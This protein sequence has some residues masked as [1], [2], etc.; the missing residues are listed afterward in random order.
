MKKRLRSLVCLLVLFHSS[1][2]A[3]SGVIPQS[4]HPTHH[5]KIRVMDNRGTVLA[6][7]QVWKDGQP[8]ERTDV[9]GELLLP[10]RER[11][12]VLTFSR[13][14]YLPVTRAFQ[15][16][17]RNPVAVVILETLLLA[18]TISVTATVTP[19]SLQDLPRAQD[20]LDRLDIRSTLPFSPVEIAQTTPAVSF[21]G[22]G[23]Q[24]ITPTI[25]GTGRRRILLLLNGVRV[26]SDRRAGTSA[27]FIPAPWITTMEVVR[28]PGSV[29]FGSDAIGGV[30]TMETVPD[31]GTIRR[32]ELYLSYGTVADETGISVIHGDQLGAGSYQ[33]SLAHSRS[34]NYKSPLGTVYNSGAENSA[35]QGS[36]NWGHANGGTVISFLGSLGRQIGKPDRENDPDTRTENPTRS[37]HFLTLHTT[38]NR[39]SGADVWDVLVNVNPF[40]YEL[41]KQDLAAETVESSRTSG[42]NATVSVSGSRRVSSLFSARYG[43]DLFLRKNLTITNMQQAPDQHAASV[44]LNDGSRS[45][46]GLFFA[47]QS[48]ESK[49]LSFMGGIRM[50][51]HATRIQLDDETIGENETSFSWQTGARY[52]VSQY[53]NGFLNISRGFR[54]PSL[55][56]RYYSGLTGRR[57]VIANPDLK[58]EQNL[59]FD[60]GIRLHHKRAS[61]GIFLFENRISRM[62]ERFRLTDGRYTHDNVS[63]GS[64]QGIELEGQLLPANWL[65]IHGSYTRYRG[66][67]STNDPLNDV[68]AASMKAGISCNHNRFV[69]GLD[70]EHLSGKPDPGP[71]EI[72]NRHAARLQMHISWFISSKWQVFLKGD[73]LSNAAYYPNADPDMPLAPGRSW[74]FGIQFSPNAA[75]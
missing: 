11:R 10:V 68:P 26:L 1:L 74:R 69:W 52:R 25:R 23:G 24:S 46:T 15:P 6:D 47:L 12:C 37:D 71:A 17:P 62:I 20:K 22:S 72:L 67:T 28:G 4:D 3:L 19:S 40:S 73:N 34:D 27:S 14:G 59:E 65:R 2:V 31:A 49:R 30:L 21:L 32:S 75:P 66:R 44:P 16:S 50:T 54:F 35:I 7:V 63:E 41:T 70:W 55:S 36:Y 9:N 53:V 38:L 57:T 61:L 51:R 43:L 56:E 48:D 8:V 60:L 33:I 18:E 29:F 64:I 39:L 45:D 42:L 58:P 5:L 13:E